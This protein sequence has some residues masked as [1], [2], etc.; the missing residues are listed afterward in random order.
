MLDAELPYAFID[1]SGTLGETI[2][3]AVLMCLS[4]G[5]FA[6]TF[7]PLLLCLYILQQ[8]YL[9]T[10][11]QLRLLDLEAKSPLYSHFIETLSGL[12]TI[13]ALGWGERFAEQSLTLLDGSQKAWYMLLCVQRWLALVLDMIV[14]LLAVILMILVVKLRA[15][16]GA[17]YVGL[18]L[19]NIMGFNMLLTLIL[20]NWTDL[21]TSVGAVARCRA[22][23]TQTPSEDL[24]GET[25]TPPPGWP[26]RGA[27]EFRNVSASYTLDSPT[28]VR[29]V[30][31]SIRAGEK[32]GICGRS[33]SGKSSLI[34]TLFRML[35]LRP[36]DPDDASAPTSTGQLIVDG[37][38]LATLPRSAVRRALNAIPQEPFL[39]R[40][41][42]R[43]NADPRGEHADA[44]IIS[45]LEKVEL[46]QLLA[47]RGGLDADVSPE[48]LSH[49]QRQLFCLA[50]A[51]L[52][53]GKVVVLDEATSSVDARTDALMQRV[54]R[55]EFGGATVIAVAHRLDTIMD[56]DRI[57]LLSAGRLV[58]L[59]TPAGLMG[60]ES[61]FRELYN[62]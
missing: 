50:R 40:A 8:F 55:A 56:F 6:A 18:A 21:E 57:A 23:A 44:A 34:T 41:S 33:G 59:D 29:G 20:K 39:L 52:R 35:E 1:G 60:R 2:I 7:P 25:T 11:R 13:R 3:G 47:A 54:I 42:V 32:L 22:F 51:V 58:E 16:M 49:G 24:D 10:S 48:L 9:R 30:N 53:G 19:L 17:G 43:V 62:S 38:D 45:A 61:R 26:S 4:A 27:I 5:Y 36:D 28:V 31:L 46:W 15:D 12:T 14:A 37:L